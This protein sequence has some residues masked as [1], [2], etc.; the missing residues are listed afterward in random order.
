METIEISIYVLGGLIILA[1]LFD[2][3]N[4]FHDAANAI[5]TVVST[6]VLKPHTAVAMAAVFNFAAIAV[7]GLK[8]ASAIG[9]GIIDAHVV[10][11]YVIFGALIGAIAWNVI[12]WYYGIPSSSSHALVG[13]LVGAAVAK[14]GTEV[15]I[16]DGLLRVVQFIVIAPLLGFVLGALIM[17]IVSWLFVKSH[18]RKVDGWFRR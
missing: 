9:K 8:V 3:M 17:L 12:T 14:G 1:L 2:F 7:V 6:G 10:D 5:A 13:G 16:G 4:G 15:L 18:P 11:E